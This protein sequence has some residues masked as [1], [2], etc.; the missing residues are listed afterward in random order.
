MLE[1][2]WTEYVSGAPRVS[3]RKCNIADVGLG[4]MF[5]GGTKCVGGRRRSGLPAQENPQVRL[6]CIR[7]G[8]ATLEER[9][10]LGIW[11]L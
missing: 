4:V 5:A 11:F 3:G 9:P 1:V 10:P 2:A 7:R 6:K 8:T